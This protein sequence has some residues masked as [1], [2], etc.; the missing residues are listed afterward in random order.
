MIGLV[1]GKKPKSWCFEKFSECMT[2]SAEGTS[3]SWEPCHLRYYRNVPKFSDGQIWANSADPDQE[4]SDQGLF[5]I[6]SA[7]FALRKRHLIQ[8]LG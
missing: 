3:T 5:A 8:L 6:P 2:N 7:S 1:A 4:Q